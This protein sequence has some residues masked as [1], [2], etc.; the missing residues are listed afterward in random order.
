MDQ[1]GFSFLSI[2]IAPEGRIEASGTAADVVAIG[3]FQDHMRSVG[4][5]LDLISL[6]LEIED[7]SQAFSVEIQVK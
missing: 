7:Q 3:T 2:A 4:D 6:Q 1:P 5:T